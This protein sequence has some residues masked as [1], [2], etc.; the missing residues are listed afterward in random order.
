MQYGPIYGI[1]IKKPN[2]KRIF[3]IYKFAAFFPGGMSQE[4]VLNYIGRFPDGTEEG[5][6]SCAM[7]L[8]MQGTVQK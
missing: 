6:T 2:F 3:R 4:R 7:I 8:K 1:V 5:N